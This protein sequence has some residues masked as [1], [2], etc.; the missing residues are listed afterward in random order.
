MVLRPNEKRPPIYPK[1]MPYPHVPKNIPKTKGKTRTETLLSCSPSPVL[2]ETDSN[3]ATEDSVLRIKNSVRKKKNS[4][5]L[6]TIRRSSRPKERVE[7]YV[8][9]TKCD[10]QLRVK[11]VEETDSGRSSPAAKTI[12]DVKKKTNKNIDDTDSGRSSPAVK[13]VQVVKKKKHQD[14]EETALARSSPATKTVQ[15]VQ[16]KKQK[17]AEEAVSERSLASNTGQVVKKKKPKDDEIRSVPQRIENVIEEYENKVCDRKLC[18]SRWPYY[19]PPNPSQRWCYRQ[20]FRKFARV[21][22]HC[23]LSH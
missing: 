17:D 18:V 21:V 1:S 15:A 12:R 4:G 10:R 11:E 14:I 7:N 2:S 16:K 9:E 5:P 20:I 6:D 19:N 8:T 13:A 3:E 23:L 22:T